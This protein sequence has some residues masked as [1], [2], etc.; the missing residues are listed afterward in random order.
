MDILSYYYHVITRVDILPLLLSGMEYPNK[1]INM[2]RKKNCMFQE[3]CYGPCIIW[4]SF[5][6]LLFTMVVKSVD[7]VKHERNLH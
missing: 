7:V 1:T 3:S 2:L 4:E 6:V 5:T